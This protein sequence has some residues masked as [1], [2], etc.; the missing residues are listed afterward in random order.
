MSERHRNEN[1]YCPVQE[2]EQRKKT[3]IIVIE[4]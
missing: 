4:I 1:K 3:T 2:K